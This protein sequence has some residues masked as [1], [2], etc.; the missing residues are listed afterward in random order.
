MKFLKL[1]LGCASLNLLYALLY[2]FVDGSYMKINLLIIVVP[3]ITYFIA[4]LMMYTISSIVKLVG[5]AES[6]AFILSLAIVF[7]MWLLF[8]YFVVGK[9]TFSTLLI[10]RFLILFLLVNIIY[11]FLLKRP[12]QSKC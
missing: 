6:K 5:F 9:K 3:T 4:F 10:N 2:G 11:F 8:F 7:I 12:T 1:F